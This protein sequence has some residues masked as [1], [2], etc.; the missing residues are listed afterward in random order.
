MDSIEQLVISNF[1]PNAGTKGFRCPD[2][3]EDRSSSSQRKQPLRITY[4]ENSAVWFCHHCESKGQM[5][6]PPIHATKNRGGLKVVPEFQKL[7]KHHLDTLSTLRGFDLQSLDDDVQKQ[8]VYSNQ[9][10]FSSLGRKTESIGF[11]YDHDAIKWRSIDGKHFAW[12]GSASSLFPSTPPIDDETI[13]LVEG[14]YDALAMRSAG[15]AAVS[16]PN[17]SSLTAAGELP[18]YLKALSARLKEKKT[19]VIIAVDADEKGVAYRNAL[20]SHLGR[21]NVG[22]VDWSEFGA[23][24]ANECILK[25]G[26]EVLMDAASKVHDVLF[27]G[28]VRVRNV[29]GSIERIRTGGFR[30]GAKIGIPSVDKLLTICSD[31]I[32]IVTGVP[33]SGKSTFIDA[34]A[35]R[36]AMQEDWKFAIFSAENPIEIH[37]GKLLEQ[38]V[39][40]PIFEGNFRM[41]N[42]QLNE[43]SRWLDEHFF[44]LDPASSN[45]LK[46]ILARAAVLVEHKKINGLIIDPFNYI[47]VDLD[48][49]SINSMLTEL[50]AAALRMHIHIF[51]VAHPQKLYRGEGG[52]MPT[53][54]G[55]DISGSASWWAK[56]DFGYTLERTEDNETKLIVWK[57]RFKWLGDCGSTYLRFDQ[58]CGRYS[59]GNTAAEI[60]ANV[61]WNDDEDK[62][63]KEDKEQ[64]DFQFSV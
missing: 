7:E 61:K 1:S 16:A 9:V 34:C 33:G 21:E 63:D 44:F 58:S 31:Q 10:F 64:I 42:D 45:S 20:I 26:V 22:Y 43:G 57:C 60:I 54:L 50:H 39:G 3:S 23:K 14:E 49:N 36:L 48:T 2:C 15:Y 55:G 62:E 37:A 30:Q 35:V 4:E 5:R 17:G 8:L 47:D 41:T 56:A 32:S 40:R 59:E 25:H 27:D 6:I 24:D 51:V 46:S 52:R 12:S 18:S 13:Y 53:P 19:N 38:Y 28:I 29:T 11:V